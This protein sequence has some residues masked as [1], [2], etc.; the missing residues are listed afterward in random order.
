MQ[1]LL[2]KNNGLVF[3]LSLALLM[4]I[5]V[6]ELLWIAILGLIIFI[7]VQIY[8]EKTFIFISILSFLTLTSSLSVELRTTVQVFNIL[9]LFYLFFKHYGLG[10]NKYPRIPRELGFLLA[11]IFFSMF[12]ATFFSHYIFLGIQQIIRLTIFLAIIYFLYSL[13]KTGDDVRLLF[14]SLI[15]VGIIYSITLFGELARNDFNFIQLNLSQ[16]DKVSGKYIN[17]NAFGSFFIIIISI[18]LS[19]FLAVKERQKKWLLAIFLTIFLVALFITNSRAAILGIAIASIFILYNLNRKLLKILF[20]VVLCIIPFLFIHPISDFI[21]VYFRLERLTTGRDA[22]LDVTYR[23]IKDNI[24]LGVGP[25]ATKFEMYPHMN[26]MLG[27]IAEKFLAFHY[28]EIEF[29]HAHNFYLFFWS[30]LGLLGL[31]TSILLPI[32]FFKI[33]L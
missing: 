18:I 25:A 13:T 31:F 17:M 28:N 7:M 3:S 29:G 10:I 21:D 33:M 22:I 4:A 8:G 11:F 12:T 20:L 16:L 23:I 26:Y 27:S 1:T 24:I 14:F 19:Y 5:L 15:T 32:I 6:P 2:Y 9:I 30:D